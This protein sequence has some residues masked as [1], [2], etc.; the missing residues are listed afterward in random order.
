MSEPVTRLC[1]V[2]LGNICRSP[3]AAAVMGHLVAEAGVAERFAL[4]SAGTG[5]WHVG[6]GADRRAVAEARRRGIEMTHRARQFAAR[7]FV[8]FDL[9]LAM[10]ADNAR[11]LRVLAPHPAAAA[12]IRLLLDFDPA[13]APGSSV[14]DPYFGGPDGFAFVFDLVERACRG[15]LTA[16]GR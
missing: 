11:D 5:G 8:R 9:V 7:D 15:L 13:S 4:E 6:E 10:D 2:C 1:F 16:L 12:K 14:P 3:T